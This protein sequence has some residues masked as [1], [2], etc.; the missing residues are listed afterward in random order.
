MA[1]LAEAGTNHNYYHAQPCRST[2][3]KDDEV[4]MA[5]PISYRMPTWPIAA[6]CA[7]E[8]LLCFVASMYGM[9][10]LRQLKGSGDRSIDL[11]RYFRNATIFA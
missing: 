7:L 6:T 4:E 3:Q 5:L 2:G 9:N 1:R 10:G 8:L 11:S